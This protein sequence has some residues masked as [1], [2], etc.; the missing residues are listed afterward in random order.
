MPLFLKCTQVRKNVNY[1]V[2]T[3]TEP[4]PPEVSVSCDYQN[5]PGQYLL[6]L[7]DVI[8]YQREFNAENNNFESDVLLVFFGA[9]S[10]LVRMTRADFETKMAQLPNYTVIT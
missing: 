5:I 8:S 6:K 4:P 1:Q 10:V 7:D 3:S 9:G 2:P